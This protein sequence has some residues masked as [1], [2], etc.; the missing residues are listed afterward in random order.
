MLQNKQ[1]FYNYWVSKLLLIFGVI[2]R[3][4]TLLSWLLLITYHMNKVI[5]KYVVNN[6][7]TLI[8][9]INLICF[10]GEVGMF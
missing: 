8:Y 6:I 3:T 2:I 5:M 7:V 10:D 1:F 4:V 9:L